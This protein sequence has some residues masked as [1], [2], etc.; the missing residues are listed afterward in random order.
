MTSLRLG[1]FVSAE[2]LFPLMEISCVYLK[3]NRAVSDP[4]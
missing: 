2:I 3:R 1:G 4:L